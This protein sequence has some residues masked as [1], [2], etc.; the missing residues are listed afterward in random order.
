MYKK[1]AV[2]ACNGIGDAILATPVLRSLRTKY[3]KSKITFIVT[4]IIKSIVEGLPFI[5]DVIVYEKG[6]PMWPVI[7]HIWRYDAAIILDF[8]YRS[9]VIPFLARIPVRAGL[10]HK[11][12]L[13]LTHKAQRDFNEENIYEPYNFAAIINKTLGISLEGDFTQL[14]IA[15]AT[16]ESKKKVDDL[17]ETLDIKPDEKIIAISTTFNKADKKDWPYYEELIDE[18]KKRVKCK[19][20]LLG[21]SN[22]AKNA[23][24]PNAFNWI[25]KTTL[26]ETGEILRRC[27]LYIGNC[28]GPLHIAAATNVPIVAIYASTSAKRWAPKHNTIVVQKE[29]LPCSPCYGQHIHCD[30]YRCL[31]S[32]TVDDVLEACIKSLKDK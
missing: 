27:N 23:N 13:F 10:A 25:G 8:K 14:Y 26:N 4:P 12:G 20:I 28:S 30:D 2:I 11:R 21:T 6:A 24:F 18:L 15:D 1:I 22:N 16:D 32:T 7:R 17:F 31:T 5:D 29:I 3:P 19:I 9:A